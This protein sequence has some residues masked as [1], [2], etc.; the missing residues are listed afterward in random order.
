VN[1]TNTEILVLS[2]ARL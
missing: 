2:R 1:Q